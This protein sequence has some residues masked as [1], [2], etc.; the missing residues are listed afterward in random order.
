MK[1]ELELELVNKYPQLFKDYRADPRVSCMAF[2]CECG[3]GW[4]HLIDEAC[5]QIMETN[6]PKDVYFVQIKQKFG[7]LVLYISYYTKEIEEIIDKFEYESNYVCEMCGTKEN[8]VR[9]K[10]FVQTICETCLEEQK[11]RFI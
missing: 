6:P 10:G 5:K 3:D 9:T 11:K 8:V 4:F 2:G 7:E 1:R